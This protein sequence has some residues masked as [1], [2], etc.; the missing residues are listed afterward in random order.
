MKHLKQYNED[1][2]DETKI[3][4]VDRLGPV[5]IKI[6][7][8][9]G[10]DVNKDGM[11]NPTN[12]FSRFICKMGVRD[13]VFVEISSGRFIL[14]KSDDEDNDIEKYDGT[15]RSA[16]DPE[17]RTKWLGATGGPHSRKEK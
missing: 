1:I 2:S 8:A 15:S 16:G 5:V 12:K 10:F 14:S 11:I 7:E 4:V 17:E 9:M 13:G 3:K 6:F